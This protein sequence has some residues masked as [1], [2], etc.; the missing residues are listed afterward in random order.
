MVRLRRLVV[1]RREVDEG[2]VLIETGGPNA[3][4][5]RGVKKDFLP[6]GKEVIVTGY[7]AKD[8]S[9]TA[10]GDNVSFPDMREF[11]GGWVGPAKG[12]PA[13]SND[14]SACGCRPARSDVVGHLCRAG[15]RLGC[16][17][18]SDACTAA[19]VR[20]PQKRPRPARYLRGLAG[21]QFRGVGPRRARR[22]HRRTCGPQRRR[23][24]HDSRIR[25]RRSQRGRTISPSAGPCRS[26]HPSAV[27]GGVTTLAGSAF[28]CG[29]QFL[30]RGH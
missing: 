22:R 13:P 19:A 10:A 29:R 3:L 11:L 25:R 24:R 21:A 17:G 20:A 9:F 16:S 18:R 7:R 1:L 23:R 28:R 12:S 4:A 15:V 6:I 27:F 8:M 2:V 30:R 26:G 14:R 5:R